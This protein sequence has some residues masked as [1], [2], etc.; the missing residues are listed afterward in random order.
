MRQERGGRDFPRTGQG[1]EDLLRK[2][3]IKGTGL[4]RRELG[5]TGLIKSDHGKIGLS[6]QERILWNMSLSVK[7]GKKEIRITL[8]KTR[9]ARIGEDWVRND[10]LRKGQGWRDR[11]C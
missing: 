11:I 8:R 2:E 1:R 9:F 10:V 7:T 4:A 3:R 5:N 6:W